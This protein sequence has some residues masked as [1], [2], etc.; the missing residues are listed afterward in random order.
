MS[1]QT[2]IAV[3][4]TVLLAAVAQPAVAQL[5]G[6]MKGDLNRDGACNI[7]DVQA[8]VAQALGA[9]TRTGEAD[10]NGD[11][12]V[13]I[14][15][16]QGGI[17]TAMGSGGLVQRV[18]GQVDCTGDMTRDR[19]RIRAMSMDGQCV[20]R[21][22]DPETG[23]FRLTLRTNT[24]WSF[25][26]LGA[27]GTGEQAQ[28]GV[29]EIPV[30][31]DV[32][33]ILPLPG[34]SQGRELN[35]GTLGFQERIRTQAELRQMFGYIHGQIDDSDANANGLPDFVE[36]LV[37]RV[38]NGPGVPHGFNGQNLNERIASCLLGWVSEITAPSLTDEDA[39][40]IPDFIE[41]LIDCIRGN[42]MQ[43]LDHEGFNCPNRDDNH[44]GVPDFIEAVVDYVVAG[45]PEWIENLDSPE[46]V[47]SN[48]NDIPDYL[49]P[50][51]GVPGGPN[52]LDPDGT[53]TPYFGRDSD[54]DGIPNCQ[55]PDAC[56]P[57]D[58][59]GDGI[60]NSEDLDDDNDEVPDYA[61]S[62]PTD[63]NIH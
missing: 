19:I 29:V 49:E 27:N 48:S 9:L 11:G 37:N 12:E 26:F 55:D 36:P 42:T 24:A 7:F 59:D 3:A 8:M 44:D 43:W 35:L 58:S 10:V 15:D 13:N 53:G 38:M 33:T 23:R 39:D 30:A 28:V 20:D 6:A 51:L 41:P 16:V 45:L 60:P 18:S 62:A 56:T 61:D 25:A 2:M 50:L 34:L 54:G 47:D 63:P 57:G 32:S 22:V 31:G 5:E 40:G 21:P 1:K 4:L 14:L 17:A 52:A 46:L